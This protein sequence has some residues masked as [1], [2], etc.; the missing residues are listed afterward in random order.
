M[1]WNIIKISNIPT[2]DIIIT[3]S[4]NSNGVTVISEIIDININSIWSRNMQIDVVT[5][6]TAHVI[7]QNINNIMDNVVHFNHRWYE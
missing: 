5:I 3:Y 7:S 2:S 6:A 1:R 4:G